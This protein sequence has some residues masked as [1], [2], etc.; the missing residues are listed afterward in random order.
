MEL[1]EAIRQLD[2]I[3]AATKRASAELIDEFVSNAKRIISNTAQSGGQDPSTDPFM[4]LLRSTQEQANEINAGAAQA[5][6]ESTRDMLAKL[7]DFNPGSSQQ[8]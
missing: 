6:A 8:Q 4:A 5:L 1:S 7:R 2:E 3:A